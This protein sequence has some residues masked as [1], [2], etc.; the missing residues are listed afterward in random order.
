MTGAKHDTEAQECI[1]RTLVEEHCRCE[2]A[3]LEG[4]VECREE[5]MPE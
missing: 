4:F 5:R 3:K 2:E 1:E